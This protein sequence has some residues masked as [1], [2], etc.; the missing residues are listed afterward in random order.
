MVSQRHT[1][2]RV[3]RSH[4]DASG[5]TLGIASGRFAGRRKAIPGGCGKIL[6]AILFGGIFILLWA[7]I[8]A[9][10]SRLGS[11]KPLLCWRFSVSSS[12]VSCRIARVS[13]SPR[14][15]EP[16]SDINAARRS[17]PSL[18]RKKKS[19]IRGNLRWPGS[20]HRQLFLRLPST[21]PTA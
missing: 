17:A 2:R 12:W 15:R 10:L 20:C 16:I 14:L 9:G 11:P 13:P 8:S 6:N 3:V 5:Q 19:R 18:C 7:V 1:E 21:E 4:R